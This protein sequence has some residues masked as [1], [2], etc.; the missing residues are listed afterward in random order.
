ML[1]KNIEVGQPYGLYNMLKSMGYG[2]TAALRGQVFYVENNAGN[3]SEDLEAGLS[4][5]RAYKTLAFAI[6]KSNAQISNSIL[7]HGRGWAARNTIFC[8]GDSIAEDLTVPPNKCDVIGCG[9]T[10]ALHKTQIIGEHAWTGSGSIVSSG[11]YNLNF[12]ND[13]TSPIFTVTSV[14]GLYFGD[15]TFRATSAATHAILLATAGHDLIVKGCRFLVGTE[16]VQDPFDIAAISI[17]ATTFLDMLIQ[18]NFVE[19]DI[20]ISIAS[21]NLFNGLI[22]NNVIRAVGLTIGDA[23]NDVVITR[24][25]LITAANSTTL[26][27]CITG[28]VALAAQN[29]V[30]GTTAGTKNYPPEAA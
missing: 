9:S 29:M 8:K 13:D 21:T 15:C 22:D 11:F 10:D 1:N 17:T 20:G 6:G 19:G 3:D 18:D 24:N 23:S 5:D 14:A 2:G 28:N 12:Y 16:T 26:T 7:G 25:M 27:D 30:T 4:W